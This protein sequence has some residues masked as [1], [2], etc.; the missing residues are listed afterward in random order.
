MIAFYFM[1]LRFNH[2][3]K[4]DSIM[5]CYFHGLENISFFSCI[6][7]I[8]FYENRA[9]LKSY[10]VH[11]KVSLIYIGSFVVHKCDAAYCL[12]DLNLLL[13]NGLRSIANYSKIIAKNEIVSQPFIMLC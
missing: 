9:H 6:S 11:R 4:S 3:L 13:M 5:F 8:A 1:S 7:V 2:H 10:H 12:V